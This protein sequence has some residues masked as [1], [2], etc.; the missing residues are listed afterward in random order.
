MNLN[1]LEIGVYIN[2]HVKLEEII[3][4]RT[5]YVFEMKNEML[6]IIEDE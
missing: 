4:S 6:V 3:Y 1:E 5:I 2:L